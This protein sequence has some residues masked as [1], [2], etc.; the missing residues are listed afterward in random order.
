MPALAVTVV[1]PVG[2]GDAFVAGYLADRLAG[3]TPEARLRTAIAAGAF[4]VTVPGDCEGL[5]PAP[6]W[7]WRE[8][9][10]LTD[11][12]GPLDACLHQHRSGG[13]SGLVSFVSPSARAAQD[14]SRMTKALVVI[15][16]QESFRPARSGRP[17]PTRTSSTDVQRLVDA[18]RAA[19]DFVV[20][21]L[22]AEP[23]TATCSTR[24]ADTS[25]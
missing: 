1:D 18:A 9:H 21:V 12:V 11:D 5:P 23:G 24:P 2:A 19:G 8:R 4:A 7:I 22:H 20:W 15:D 10:P 14:E 6:T 17:S 13:R 3:R 25:G 16:V